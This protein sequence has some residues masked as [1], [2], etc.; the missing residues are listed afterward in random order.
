MRKWG[1][2]EVS[3]EDEW[4]VKYHIVVPKSY[5][6]Y[7]LSTAHET[8]LSGYMGVNKTSQKILNHFYWPGL[9]KDVVEF[10]KTCH[11]CHLVGKPNKA[12]LKAPL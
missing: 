11:A 3:I 9:R 7:I 10:C 2:P 8:P 1:P 6:Q 12:I 4:A 5:I